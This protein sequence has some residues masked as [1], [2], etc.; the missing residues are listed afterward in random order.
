MKQLPYWLVG[1]LLKE[2]VQLIQ[3]VPLHPV[4]LRVPGGGAA[5]LDGFSVVV[6]AAV[7][8]PQIV[9]DVD[10][11]DVVLDNPVVSGGHSAHQHV[12]PRAPGPE[13]LGELALVDPPLVLVQLGVLG[14]HVGQGEGGVTARDYSGEGG[15]WSWGLFKG[16]I[17]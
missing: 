11:V 14:D 4:A 15:L 5:A 6:H 8:V 7:C 1:E 2:L 3:S 17:L 13:Q 12:G 9:G 16:D 10:A